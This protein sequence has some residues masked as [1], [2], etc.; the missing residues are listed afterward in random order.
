MTRFFEWK[1]EGFALVDVTAVYREGRRL[2]D[3]LG[4][5][6]TLVG[7][8]LPKSARLAV[9]MDVVHQSGNAF[10]WIDPTA[11][12]RLVRN[13]CTR[14][15]VKL[16]VAER[17][18]EWPAEWKPAG[19]FFVAS[20]PFADDL[21]AFGPQFTF[22]ISTSG[23]TGEPKSV[24]VPP[25]AVNPNVEDF[26][27]RFELKATSRVLWS[28]NLDFDPS[29]LEL[30]VALRVEC[31][32]FVMPLEFA[33]KIWPFE[34]AIMAAR[35]TFLQLTP[36]VLSL[37][38][39]DFRSLLFGPNSPVRHLL[40]GGD[41]FPS[42]LVR[43]HAQANCPMRVYN[44]YGVT[45]VSC[46]ASCTEFNP[47]SDEHADAS[48]A[49]RG[50]RLVFGPEGVEIHGRECVVNGERRPFVQTGDQ[51]VR[52]EEDGREKFLITS[53]DKINGEVVTREAEEFV[54]AESPHVEAA[55]LV[56]FREQR[57]LFVQRVAGSREAV[58][59]PPDFKIRSVFYVEELPLTTNGKP[60]QVGSECLFI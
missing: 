42:A 17:P 46:W 28:T 23:S 53:R 25:T 54:V 20:L 10:C 21:N 27:D 26:V 58:E 19:G 59:L 50:T 33:G 16:L 4:C 8:C 3:E 7:L 29:I 15:R 57:F 43:K 12:Q 49:I 56:V 11:D 38:S 51:F 2:V 14:L 45:E 32:L 52:V 44:L 60:F 47:H 5:A 37:F 6:N 40:I 35:P 39:E 31:E 18:L 1:A 22:A 9:L 30:L 36:A 13:R 55:R 48:N 24:L 34:R 41:T